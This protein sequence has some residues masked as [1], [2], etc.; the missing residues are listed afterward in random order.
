MIYFNRIFSNYEQFQQLFGVME[1]GN[2]TKSRKNKIL[3]SLLKNRELLHTMATRSECYHNES[4]WSERKQCWYEKLTATCVNPFDVDW[5][6]ISSMASLYKAL[7]N[8][9]FNVSSG[10]SRV[11]IEMGGDQII[12]WSNKYQTDDFKGLCEDGDARSIRYYNIERG[13]VFK[14]RAGKFLRNLIEENERFDQFLPEQIKIWFCEEFA[15][16]WKAYAAQQSSEYELVV[17]DDFESIYDSSCCEGDFG[18]C[19]VDD[20]YWSFYRDAVSAKAA[21]LRNKNG[22]I[23]ARCIIYTDVQTESGKV[24]RLAERQYATDCDETLKRQLVAALVAAKE[25]DGYKRVGADC[26][27]PRAFVGND[28]N[29]LPELRFWIPCELG[30]EDTVSYQDSFKWYVMGEHKAYNYEVDFSLDLAITG[31]ELEEDHSNEEWSSYNEE[32]IPSD[33]AYYVDTRDDYFWRNQ[34]VRAYRCGYREWCFEDDCIEIDDDYYYAGYN[35]ESPEDYGIYCCDKCGEWF[36]EDNCCHSELTGYDYCCDDCMEEAEQEY[37][38][39]YWFYSEYD[40]EYYEDSSDVVS[41][42]QWNVF[43]NR[44]EETTIH[45]ETLEDLFGNGEAVCIEGITY[46][47]DIGFDGEPI[48]FCAASFK[49][50]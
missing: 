26:H 43:A 30:Y 16:R 38:E 27:S 8:A 37:K 13:R 21:S 23:V 6:S 24:L 20:D 10:C 46:I 17:D 4:H 45:V 41:V 18:S 3:L 15:E 49:V 40:D 5:L 32:Y 34:V 2:G 50:A 35:A 33:E 11:N 25:I 29:P 19:M 9:L 1:H 44:Y 28:G 39:N 48:H 7:Q 31:G 12:V 22:K 47:D 14:M 42:M 36:H